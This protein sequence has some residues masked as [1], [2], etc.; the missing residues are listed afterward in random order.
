MVLGADGCEWDFEGIQKPLKSP[1]NMSEIISKVL[2]AQLLS[3]KYTV[4]AYTYM[5]VRSSVKSTGVSHL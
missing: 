5:Y 1:F 2:E 4:N 3:F